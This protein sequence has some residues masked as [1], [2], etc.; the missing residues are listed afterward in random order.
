MRVVRQKNAHAYRTK[1][2]RLRAFDTMRLALSKMRRTAIVRSREAAGVGMDGAFCW[3]SNL[4][5]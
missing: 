5:R 1:A 3:S 4:G 2:T